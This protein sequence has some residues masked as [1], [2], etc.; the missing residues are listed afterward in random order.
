MQ[1]KKISET[2]W[3]PLKV[4]ICY[5]YPFIASQG[6]LRKAETQ[7]KAPFHQRATGCGGGGWVWTVSLPAAGPSRGAVICVIYN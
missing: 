5:L 7:T 1:E 4:S 3:E 6:L 2:K